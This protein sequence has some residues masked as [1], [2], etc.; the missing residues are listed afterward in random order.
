[1]NHDIVDGLDCNDDGLYLSDLAKKGYM[2]LMIVM[3]PMLMM[4][5][6]ENTIILDKVFSID[7]AM[8]EETK[9]VW[10]CWCYW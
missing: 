2:F 10:Y 7:Q 1:M 5:Q 3:V 6:V 4:M 8:M 9:I